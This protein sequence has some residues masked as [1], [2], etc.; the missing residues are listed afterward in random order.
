MS[1]CLVLPGN[2]VLW[3]NNDSERDCDVLN[4]ME[5]KKICRIHIT[6]SSQ[7]VAYCSSLYYRRLGVQLFHSLI[8]QESE[9]CQGSAINLE[10]LLHF[11]NLCQQLKT[12]MLT[13]NTVIATLLE[14]YKYLSIMQCKKNQELAVL[15]YHP[16]PGVK[17]N[18]RLYYEGQQNT[19]YADS[20]LT[21]FPS[22][23]VP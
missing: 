6:F 1:L 10:G 13:W 22:V 12:S 7:N 15:I 17:E 3:W 21:Q 20:D 23:T 2:V 8:Q 11:S 19:E 4:S 14:H 16:S 5:H 9:H 18:T